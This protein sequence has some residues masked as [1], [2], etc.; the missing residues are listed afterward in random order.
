MVSYIIDAS[1]YAFP[2]QIVKYDIDEIP[3]IDKYYRDLDTMCKLFTS[4]QRRD[5]RCF[6]VE[7][8]IKLIHKEQALTFTKE[9]ASKINAKPFFKRFSAPYVQ[10][11]LAH[12]FLRLRKENP[13]DKLKEYIFFEKWFHIKDI[14]FESNKEPEIP[15][16]ILNVNSNKKL[17]ENLRKNLAITA[18]LNRRLFNDKTFL[19]MIINYQE[20]EIPINT[21]IRRT[22]ML[23][24]EYRDKKNKLIKFQYILPNAPLQKVKITDARV[25]TATIDIPRDNKGTLIGVINEAKTWPEL[26]FGNDVGSGINEYINRL[27]QKSATI[28]DAG[29]LA[30]IHEIKNA[31][32]DILYSYLDTLRS[33]VTTRRLYKG[34]ESFEK[35]FHCGYKCESYHTCKSYIHYLG[36]DCVC[37]TGSQ[38]RCPKVKED[39]TKND[40]KG[41]PMVFRLHLRPYTNASGESSLDFLT[42]RI[43]FINGINRII[44]G[45]IGAHLF[46]AKKG[47][48]VNNAPPYCQPV[49]GSPSC[50][51]NYIP[52]PGQNH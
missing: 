6:L 13:E 35:R 5:I 29:S 30:K 43:H 36:L 50:D 49:C 12:L 20:T 4:E 31:L 37:E 17:R 18:L 33:Y 9:K 52:H 10:I 32:P 42:M 48:L 16:D 2:S 22:I 26:I 45:H 34:D 7:R 1:F 44:I 39:R 3:C 15:A 51:P 24:D 46:L 14:E 23:D 47:C 40:E 28:I 19:K 25:K 27:E 8:D 11:R 38:M 21:E 41:N